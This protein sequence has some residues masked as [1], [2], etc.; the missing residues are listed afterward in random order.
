MHVISWQSIWISRLFKNA[1]LAGQRK[2]SFSPYKVRTREL[3]VMQEREL[4]CSTPVS[5]SSFSRAC[6]L[7]A[8]VVTEEWAQSRARQVLCLRETLQSGFLVF[9]TVSSF[10]LAGCEP[11][12]LLLQTPKGWSHRPFLSFKLAWKPRLSKAVSVLQVRVAAHCTLSRWALALEDR[13]CLQTRKSAKAKPSV[14]SSS[15]I[16][17][18]RFLLDSILAA[19]YTVVCQIPL[20]MAAMFFHCSNIVCA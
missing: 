17:P 1:T 2:S 5:Q 3:T 10:A 20:R 11:K 13:K 7:D 16:W 4:L 15:V 19:V 6:I 9:E 12:I 18:E 14:H 8:C